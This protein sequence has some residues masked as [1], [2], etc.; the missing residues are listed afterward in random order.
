MSTESA[1]KTLYASLWERIGAALIDTAI[2]APVA[3][4]VH[5]LLLIVPGYDNMLFFF[6]LYLPLRCVYTAFYESSAYQATPG[7]MCMGFKVTTDENERISFLRAA[8]RFLLA[9]VLS[10]AL[11]LG[12]GY[13]VIFITPRRQT[14]HDLLLTTVCPN[15]PQGGNVWGRLKHFL[16]QER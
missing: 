12:L 16:R 5:T 1:K 2:T 7:E 4:I 10:T 9:E 15:A 13:L 6:C 14:L 11:L 8:S 3:F